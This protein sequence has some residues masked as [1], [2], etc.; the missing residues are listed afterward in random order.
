MTGKSAFDSVQVKFKVFK[1][2]VVI[3]VDEVLID[4]FVWILH[5]ICKLVKQ[6]RVLPLTENCGDWT[7][8]KYFGWWT[9]NFVLCKLSFSTFPHGLRGKVCMQVRS[10]Y[11]NERTMGL[12]K[13]K[14]FLLK[15]TNKLATWAESIHLND[16]PPCK[17]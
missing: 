8:K 1:V 13:N 2:Y 7:I 14:H 5:I 4:L 9:K 12:R 3:H 17:L 16:C 10:Y 15:Y 11:D 6:K